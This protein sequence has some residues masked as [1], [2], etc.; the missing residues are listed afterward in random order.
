M[1]NVHAAMTECFKTN[2]LI[3]FLLM[4]CDVSSNGVR[5]DDEKKGK[6]KRKIKDF[7]YV[8]TKFHNIS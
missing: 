5:E 3:F 6:K 2:A 7:F 1:R 8:K 4:K